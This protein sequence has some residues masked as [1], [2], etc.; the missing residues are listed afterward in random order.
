MRAPGASVQNGKM[1]KTLLHRLFGVGRIPGR[2]RTALETEGVVV[3]DEGIAGSVT[4]RHFRVPGRRFRF[5]RTW[6]TGSVIVTQ[7][8]IAAFAWGRRV[9]NVPFDDLRIREVG[10][11][12]GEDTLLITFEAGLFH[13]E[14]SGQVE[15]RYRTGE[16]RRLAGLLE[17]ARSRRV[18]ATGTGT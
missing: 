10:V 14:M 6:F 9:V 7:K 16:A 12:A 4:Y 2:F 18:A 1:I 5:R 15:L 13:E 17:E 8:R 11:L 3:V